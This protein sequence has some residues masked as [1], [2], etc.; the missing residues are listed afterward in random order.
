MAHPMTNQSIGQLATSSIAS[1]GYLMT[2]DLSSPLSATKAAQQ[3]F[4]FYRR[5]DANDPELYVAGIAAVLTAYPEEVVRHV[6]RPGGELACREFMPGQ[7][8]V[9]DAC[10]AA[11]EPRRKA[12]L[13]A[14]EFERRQRQLDERER[15]QADQAEMRAD[16]VKRLEDCAAELRSHGD[17]QRRLP[18]DITPE[19]AEQKLA[20]A[21]PIGP[22]LADDLKRLMALPRSRTGLQDHDN[23]ERG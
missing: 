14:A 12:E 18:N 19:Q 16:D 9:K 2:Q 6:V 20:H 4:G 21:K 10:E 22:E 7:G 1:K 15:W 5:G 11:M 3:L 8:H 23:G 17:P 13:R